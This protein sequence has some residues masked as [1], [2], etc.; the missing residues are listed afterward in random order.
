M[1]IEQ[2]DMSRIKLKTPLPEKKWKTQDGREI[3]VSDMTTTHI[4]NA[5]R[6]IKKHKPCRI[7]IV[8]P[9]GFGK[10]GFDDCFDPDDIEQ[11]P[12]PLYDTQIVNYHNWCVAF[13]TELN[14]RGVD[15]P[16]VVEESEPAVYRYELR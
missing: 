7:K 15:V 13:E 11:K 1:T 4:I 9:C 6:Y 3:A 10:F 5:Y 2:W 14:R 12:N 16:K 8:L